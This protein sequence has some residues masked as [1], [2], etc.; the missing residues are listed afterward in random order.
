MA[1]QHRHRVIVI[2]DDRDVRELLQVLLDLDERFDL[3]GIAQDG[4]DGLRQVT[5]KDPDAVVVDLDLPELDGLR[6][7]AEVRA[8]DRNIPIVVFS[9]FPDPYTLL[10][11]LRCGA[12]AYLDKAVAWAELVP[13]LLS[14]CEESL[15]PS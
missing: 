11:V 10:E 8:N 14:L 9:A 3:V 12:D 15:Q 4:A 6:V 5:D 1:N 7:I 13:T 2:D